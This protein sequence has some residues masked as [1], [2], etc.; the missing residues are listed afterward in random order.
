MAISILKF[1]FAGLKYN[2]GNYYKTKQK[3]QARLA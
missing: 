1:T 2:H 3:T